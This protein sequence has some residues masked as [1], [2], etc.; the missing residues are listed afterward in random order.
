MGGGH[1]VFYQSSGSTV[2]LHLGFSFRGAGGDDGRLKLTPVRPLEGRQ[3][4]MAA[5][6]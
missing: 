4:M 2:L 5:L 6:I 3:R 1:T